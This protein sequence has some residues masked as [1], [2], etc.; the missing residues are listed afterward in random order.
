MASPFSPET[1]EANLGALPAGD[2]DLLVVGGGITGAGVA[3]DAALRGLRVALIERNDFAAGTSSRS[4]KLIHGGVRYLQ[5]GDI[6]LVRES[7]AERDVLGKIAPH[8]A[9]PRRMVMPT[10]SRGM[11]AKLS[12][13]LWGFDKLA[14]IAADER[15]ETWTRDDT[16]SREPLLDGRRL[17]G[18]VV[19]T[20]Y[21]TDDAR[22]VLDT[23]RGA[24]D[25]GALVANHAEVTAATRAHGTSRVTVRDTLTGTTRE[26]VAR[27][28]VNAGGPW[29]D[30]VRRRAGALTGARMH[31][32]K[33]VHLV[34]RHERLPLQHIVVMVARDK[35][36]V[37]AV[38]RG[39]CT[40][41]G[42]TDTDYGSPADNPEV[43]ADDV[44][45]LL[46]AANRTFT[47]RPLSS[48]DVVAS[49][50]GL[51]PLLHEEGK[52]PSEISR[53]DEVM[54]DSASGLISIA[55]GKLTTHRRM[56]ER[57]VDLVTK[58]LGGKHQPCRTGQVP[59]PNGEFTAEELLVL[60][61]TLKER[62]PRL[63]IPGAQRLVRLYGAGA[64]RILERAEGS[65]ASAESLPGQPEVLRAEIAHSLDEEMPLT[66]EDLLE[67]RT[68]LLL[69]DAR[70]GLAGAEE[71]ASIAASRLGW[72]PARVM[73]ELDAY[74]RL[75]ASLRRF[76]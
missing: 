71:T 50:A 58:R 20:E 22:L 49:W 46:D 19:F 4:S 56:A 53:K 18:A 15:H 45:Y 75:A 1:R 24:H 33:G 40:Y 42:T 30:E 27:S 74:Q 25:A 41:L 37:F 14:S 34:V 72:D 70:Q 32:T 5:Q 48:H 59:L 2:F 16:L 35:R 44:A 29:V 12:I 52:N 76:A 64:V 26:V 60:Q 36:S 68:R 6:A 38:P 23:V 17:Y 13:G 67:R 31:L 47:G 73:A 55:G 3:R 61:N 43:T 69:F 7:A 62:I 10:Y 8:L 66:L 21:L 28:V 54:E 63:G 51:R 57:V 65:P 11:H 39:A 9:L